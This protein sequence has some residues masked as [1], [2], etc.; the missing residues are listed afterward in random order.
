MRQNRF[1]LILAM[2][3][4]AMLACTVPSSQ[5]DVVVAPPKKQITI[6]PAETVT[7]NAPHLTLTLSPTD[8][9]AVPTDTQQASS[10]VASQPY[11]PSGF[12]AVA[13]DQLSVTI[14]NLQGQPLAVVRTPGMSVGNPNSVHVMGSV[15]GSADNVPVI[16]INMENQGRIMHNLND[17]I[18]VLI[19]GPD[20][21]NLCGSP[22]ENT[23]IFTKDWRAN[24]GSSISQLYV[25]NPAA[26]NTTQVHEWLDAN[27]T[28]IFPLVFNS[29]AASN[30]NEIW[31]TH[32]LWGIGGDIVFPPQ[33]GLFY[34]D[35]TTQQETLVLTADFNPIGLSP[36]Q[37]W[38]AYVPKGQGYAE[39]VKLQLTLYDLISGIM[40]QIPLASGSDRGAGYAAFSPDDRYVA[41]MEGS[42]RQ[43]AEVPNFTSLV[44]VADM[45]GNIFANLPV[46]TL[47]S[48]TGAVNPTWA[49]PVGWIDGET[50][51][52]EIRGD[53]WNNPALVRVRFDGSGIA[54]LASGSFAGFVYP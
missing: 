16:F 47:A 19:P 39:G 38:V 25:Y 15:A 11:H 37:A 13:G 50:L 41:W 1:L 21:A 6:T 12:V 2:L 35:L 10:T 24:D 45:D 31:L 48:V 5:P 18:T 17:Q 44:R 3:L 54:Y 32:L 52:V 34:F 23:F 26:G 8:T 22:G 42:G 28:V 40:T 49:K 43:M 29:V 30:P 27:S 20:V 51:I 4:G 36:D 9:V 33:E 7:S 46:G 53:D 14:Y